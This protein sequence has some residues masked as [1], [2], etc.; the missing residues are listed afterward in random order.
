M[1]AVRW[2]TEAVAKL[3]RKGEARYWQ[4]EGVGARMLAHP[5][6][7]AAP[8]SDLC[9]CQRLKDHPAHVVAEAVAAFAEPQDAHVSPDEDECPHESW[10]QDSAGQPH[11]CADCKR[12]FTQAEAEVR[13]LGKLLDQ[14]REEYGPVPEDVKAQA[15]AQWPKADPEP[16]AVQRPVPLDR[17]ALLGVAYQVGN[18]MYEVLVHPDAQVRLVNGVLEIGHGAEWHKENEVTSIVQVRTVLVGRSADS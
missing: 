7:E 5:F 13:R 12:V 17:L 14:L 4:G 3:C 16:P 9:T 1:S 10:E 11:R 15:E 6:Q 2:D 8:G 18:T